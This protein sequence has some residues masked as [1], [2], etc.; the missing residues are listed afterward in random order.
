MWE[1]GSYDY[2]LGETCAEYG[3]CQFSRVC[4]SPEPMEWLPAYFERRRW[5]PLTRTET[6]LEV[7]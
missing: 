6:L 4:K 5:D 7:E 1:L 2:N 3:G